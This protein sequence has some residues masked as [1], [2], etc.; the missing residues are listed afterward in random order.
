MKMNT[1][2]PSSVSTFRLI[3]PFF[4]FSLV[5]CVHMPTSRVI[6]TGPTASLAADKGPVAIAFKPKLNDIDITDYHSQSITKAYSNGHVVKTLTD[7]LDFTVKTKTVGIDKDNQ[8]ATYDLK[9]IKKTGLADL[10]D[11]ALPELGETLD[12][13]M[14]NQGKVLKAG[15]Y[16]PGT[17]FFVPPVS[18]PDNPVKVGDSWSMTSEWVSLKSGVPLKM[19]TLSTLKSIRQCGTTGKCAEITLTGTVELENSTDS[20]TTDSNSSSSDKTSPAM[21]PQ[22]TSSM[23]GSLLFSLDRGTVLYSYLKSSESLS[24]KTTR[25]QIESCMVTRVSNPIDENLLGNSPLGCDPSNDL[26]KY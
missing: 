21:K 17:L 24:A 1:T 6:A 10:A 7:S 8:N 3:L 15:D 26:P 9:T 11:F 14:T 19:K 12:L 16:P 2:R 22:F 18:L 4:F 25:I 5:G 20:S 13:I 23:S